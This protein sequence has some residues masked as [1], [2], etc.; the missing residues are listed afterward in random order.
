M[1]SFRSLP[2][3]QTHVASPEEWSTVIMVIF[4]P[5]LLNSTISPGLKSS[6]L[7]LLIR[8]SILCISY[9]HTSRNFFTK[10]VYSQGDISMF[11]SYVHKPQKY[12]IRFDLSINFCYDLS[13]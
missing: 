13:S 11:F 9:R 5:A 7:I 12:L 4:G 10:L 3:N 8:Y 6:I 1:T 2:S